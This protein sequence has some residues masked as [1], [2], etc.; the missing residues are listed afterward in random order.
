MCRSRAQNLIGHLFA[1]IVQ[2]EEQQ[3]PAAI[4]Q[5]LHSYKD[6]FE[7]PKALPPHIFL[8]HHINLKPN[9]EPRNQRPYRYPFVQK[10]EIEKLIREMLTAG[11]I[12][13]SHSPFA[14]PVILVKK[15]DGTWRFCVDYR[16]LNEGTIKDKYPI[17]L[18]DELLDELHG[19]KVFSK[20]DLHSGYHQ[21]RMHEADIYKTV[22]RTHV[23]ILNSKLCHSNSL[24][25][26][27]HFNL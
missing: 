27:L 17:P 22:F 6:V 18:I 3:T 14:S 11:I 1:I 5:L 25:L 8:D 13:P 20:I 16:K 9:F 7:E 23:G 26:Q 15:K 4:Q 19:S 10:S 2:E 21:V 24:M 12:Q